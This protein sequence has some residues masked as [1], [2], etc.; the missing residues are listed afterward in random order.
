MGLSR[1]GGSPFVYRGDDGWP[2]SLPYNH[3]ITVNIA[4]NNIILV[5]REKTT[6]GN[7]FSSLNRGRCRPTKL[8]EVI[9]TNNSDD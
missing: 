3:H 5:K 8:G 9:E 6:S 7:T 1:R 2:A 4:V